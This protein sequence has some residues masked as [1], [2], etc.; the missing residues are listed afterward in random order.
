[1]LFCLVFFLIFWNDF[2]CLFVKG[3]VFFFVCVLFCCLC[4][5][6]IL[7]VSFSLK[8]M[9]LLHLGWLCFGGFVGRL[10]DVL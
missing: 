3:I 10:F 8:C 2:W 5:F 4:C 7:K 1:M 9:F 6:V